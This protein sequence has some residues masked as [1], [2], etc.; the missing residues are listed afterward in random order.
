MTALRIKIN[1]RPMETGSKIQPM[2][3]EDETFWRLRAERKA[4]ERRVK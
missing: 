4:N 2:S 1:R 3:R